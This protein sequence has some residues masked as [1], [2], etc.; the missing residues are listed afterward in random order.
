LD[1]SQ[2]GIYQNITVGAPRFQV[3]FGGG[4]LE[5]TLLKIGIVGLAQVGKTTLFEILTRAHAAGQGGGKAEARV[6]VVRVPDARLDRLAEMYH[7]Q[8][9]I[10]ATVEY[11]DTPGSII[12][13]TRAGVQSQSLRELNALAHVVRA[14]EDPVIAAEGAANPARDIENV[15]LELILSD[16]AV[17]EKR[18]ERLEKDV[19]KQKNAALEKELQVL[20]VCKSSLEKQIPLRDAALTA[21]DERVIRGFTF[22]SLKPMLYVLNLGEKD[23]GRAGAAEQFAQQA[24]LKQRPHTAVA[25]ICGKVEAEL[26]ELNEAEAAEF[27]ASYGLTESAIFRLIRASYQLLGLISFFTVGEDECRAWTIRA[28]TS[29]LEA[30][31]EIHTDLQR[32]FIRAEVVKYDDLLAAGGLPEARARAQLRLEGK[33]YIVHDGEIVHIRHSG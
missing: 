12:D 6:G 13:L 19:K 15:E 4:Y 22:L 10:H 25:A 11:L 26:A 32:G 14:F 18:L 2:K 29:A 28:G 24:G 20:N 5:E 30:A 3:G 17:V 33:D 8:K 31:G 27:L 23:A 1:V 21:E 7:P 9:T 16:L